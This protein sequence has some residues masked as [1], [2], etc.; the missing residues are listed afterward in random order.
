VGNQAAR[1]RDVL[2]TSASATAT[3]LRQKMPR[4]ASARVAEQTTGR[5]PGA[6]RDRRQTWTSR[7]VMK[8]SPESQAATART[9]KP[10]QPRLCLPAHIVEGR[11]AERKVTVR[12]LLREP[13]SFFVDQP[14]FGGHRSR[15]SERTRGS[16]AERQVSTVVKGPSSGS[17]PQVRFAFHEFR[18]RYG[19]DPLSTASLPRS[20]P[21]TAAPSSEH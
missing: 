18:G 7:R 21:H 19:T 20:S 2:F 8:N 1:P 9:R 3:A 11:R 16:R 6:H 15:R 14:G 12:R 13:Q 5:E 4:S 17:L 10:P